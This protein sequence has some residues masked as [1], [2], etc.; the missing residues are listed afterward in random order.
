MEWCWCLRSSTFQPFQIFSVPGWNYC[1]YC[2]NQVNILNSIGHLPYS[3]PFSIWFHLTPGDKDQV[4][5]RGG[6]V[7]L[8]ERRSR[9]VREVV[10]PYSWRQRPGEWER[11]FCLTP[12]D[13]AQ[14]SGRGG[15][16]LLLETR[17]RWVREVVLS[18]SLRQGPGEW[19]RW[20]CL[21]PGDKVQVSERGGSVLLLETRSRWV[22]EMVLSYSWR[23]GP[24]EWERWFC[25]TPGEHFTKIASWKIHP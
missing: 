15:S 2:V 4:S 20:F 7:L 8:L 14:V 16:V 3:Y 25:L 13:K 5:E 17:S 21:T 1:F 10:L 22:R 9:L 18:Y 6:S 12:K 24:G 19:E 11:W 23:Q